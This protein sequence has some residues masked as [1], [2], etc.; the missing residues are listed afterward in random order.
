MREKYRVEKFEELAG[1]GL[2]HPVFVRKIYF[3]FY[4]LTYV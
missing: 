4:A 2:K 1:V 3:D